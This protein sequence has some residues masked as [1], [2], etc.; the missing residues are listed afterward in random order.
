MILDNKLKEKR[1][2]FQLSCLYHI[3][4]MANECDLAPRATNNELSSQDDWLLVRNT[5]VLLAMIPIMLE[6]ILPD[7]K[8]NQ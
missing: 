1:G 2:D 7:V 4:L 8:G 5:N 6:T 3:V